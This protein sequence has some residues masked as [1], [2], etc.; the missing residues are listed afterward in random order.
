M[1]TFYANRLILDQQDCEL[2]SD[3]LWG[4]LNSAPAPSLTLLELALKVEMACPRVNRGHLGY[5]LDRIEKAE[6]ILPF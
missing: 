5:Y 4:M 2:L 6:E 3:A 1:N